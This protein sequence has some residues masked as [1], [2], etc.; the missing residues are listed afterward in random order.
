MTTPCQRWRDGQ[1]RYRPSGERIRSADYAVD[2]LDRDR[3]ARAFVVA[4]HYEHSYPAAQVRAGLFR[5]RAVG[6]ELVGVVVFGVPAQEATIPAWAPGLGPREGVVLS[7]LVLLDEVPGDGESWTV[8]RALKLLRAELPQVRA[9]VSYSDPCER[10]DAE[11]R[12]VKRGHIGVVYQATNARYMGRS[13][14]E[15]I[16]LD[17]TGRVVSRRGLSKLRNGERGGRHVYERLL[18]AGLPARDCGEDWPAYLG[19]VLPALQRVRHP[20]QHVY[21]WAWRGAELRPGLPYP[22]AGGAGP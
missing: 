15:T 4:H 5:Q 3:D 8:A 11:G 12:V 2:L 10:V 7:R 17:A 6:S 14:S 21:G 16:L 20:G 22:R 18:A 13:K 19:R 1:A 9:V